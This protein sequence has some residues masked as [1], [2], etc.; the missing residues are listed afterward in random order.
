MLDEAC[1][2]DP[3]LRRE[4]ESLLAVASRAD[5]VLETP[6]AKRPAP[7]AALPE[8]LPGT[9]VAH[10]DVEEAIGHG[11]MGAVYRARDTKL[12]RPV[13]LKFLH[14][15]E[16]GDAWA[17][18]RLEQEARAAAALDHENVGA[19]HEI[20]EWNGRPYIVMSHYTGRTLG[21]RLCEGA[22][23]IGEARSI[24]VEI[25]RGLAAA[26]AAGIVHRDLKPD[27]VM[28]TTDGR[29]KILDF[30]LAKRLSKGARRLTDPGVVLGTVGYMA[31]EQVRGEDAGAACDVWAF[32]VIAYEMLGGRHPFS[33][34]TD[35]ATLGRI[36]SIAP[37]PLGALRPDLEPELG[38]LVMR[39][40]SQQPG[41]RPSNTEL[42]ALG[43]PVAQESRKPR[44]ARA[45]RWPSAFILVLALIAVLAMAS[46]LGVRREH[47]GSPATS[48]PRQDPGPTSEI[49]LP[50]HPTVAIMNVEDLSGNAEH[51]YLAAALGQ[52]LWVELQSGNQLRMVPPDRVDRLQAGLGLTTKTPYSSETLARIK[53]AL[54]EARHVI[55]SSC[56]ARSQD[57]RVELMFS[58][59]LQ[60]LD[61]DDMATWKVEKPEE[62]LFEI[63][64]EAAAWVRETLRVAPA[65]PELEAQ[66]KASFIAEPDARRSYYEGIDELRRYR[67][68]EAQSS[69]SSATRTAPGHPLPPWA[70][71]QAWAS[72]GYLERAKDEARHAFERSGDLPKELQ[73]SIEGSYRAV[74]H[75]W[76]KAAS[77]YRTLWDL[78]PDGVEH[79]V[80][81]AEA[82]A[83]SGR[84]AEALQ[85]VERLKTL[86]EP[87]GSDVSIP[88][89]ESTIHGMMREFGKQRL[90]AR[91]A[92]A[93][94]ESRG[95]RAEAARGKELL[96]A[97]LEAEGA[98]DEAAIQLAAS[99][100][101]YREVGD[102]R[103]GARATATLAR[104][105]EQSGSLA[106][107]LTTFDEA[108]ASFRD[109]GDKA[110]EADTL[111][112]SGRL[113]ARTGDAPR[114][115]ESFDAAL[116]LRRDTRDRAGEGSTLEAIGAVL[117][118]KNDL[119]RARRSF[120]DAAAVFEQTMDDA[121]LSDAL[122]NVA[123]IRELE[124]DLDVAFAAQ[125]KV[126]ELSRKRGADYETA[127]AFARLGH[128]D[129]RRGESSRA[130][131]DYQEA[132]QLCSR[133]S[134][135]EATGTLLW[136]LG[137]IE[138][139]SGDA[140]AARRH[141]EKG[142]AMAKGHDRV[143]EIRHALAL[144]QCDLDDGHAG[145]AA[146]TVEVLIESSRRQQLVDE[147]L[148]ATAVLVRAR[149]AQGNV[150]GALEA[151]A[152]APS[153]QQ[154][155]QETL[156]VHLLMA[157][158]AARKATALAAE[159]ARATR[160]VQDAV[161]RAQVA[162][163]VELSLEARVEEAILL[164]KGRGEVAQ[165]AQKAGLLRLARL[166][167]STPPA[168]SSRPQATSSSR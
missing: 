3:A 28:I 141:H 36:L 26:H 41:E 91:D 56:F 162:H 87:L 134:D 67:A 146:R 98:H 138:W 12:D 18:Q 16:A 152:K 108:L 81:L 104:V 49:K 128:I 116:A 90:A 149:L 166:A 160:L 158:A 107:A 105:R 38:G 112:S 24:L 79:G 71:S 131:A 127:A 140:A 157:E 115:L 76:A 150:T 145:D 53:D 44:Q 148:A 25:A 111:V 120:E 8:V 2:D 139:Q 23:S 168:P 7:T 20:G 106:V 113:L 5:A 50:D 33:S 100:R 1:R 4:V 40:L 46:T 15:L 77:I 83:M 96:G 94:A 17:R 57:G 61:A 121:G 135:P 132:L 10:Y 84:E 21:E 142:L 6:I 47:R 137:V 39:C 70:L 118:Q 153:I 65:D 133:L 102:V 52:M 37:P 147:E 114:A 97:A 68:R 60:R 144:A 143:L 103:A 95:L 117:W 62:Q 22:M 159:T 42:V 93:R 35:L 167:A 78:E 55:T 14:A 136:D 51:A 88:L 99:A 92:V 124:G 11:G 126:V 109:A 69:L 82:L 86:P 34:A 74:S 154:T 101:L 31:P 13:A 43:S 9:L 130:I 64:A 54:P 123:A 163:D 72:L 48:M 19:V 32:G 63:V 85:V 66:S 161:R 164:D 30:G 110:G 27:N 45:W 165:D 58:V 156:R 125:E 29:V 122:V 80:D 73:L 75:D 89:V 151:L 59:T 119:A 155:G 129:R